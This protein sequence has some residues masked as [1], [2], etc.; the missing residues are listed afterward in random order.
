M[1]R[2][3]LIKKLSKSS[4]NQAFIH[5]ESDFEDNG[6]PTVHDSRPTNLAGSTSPITHV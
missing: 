3:V 2:R 5:K 4:A 1:K 6:Q